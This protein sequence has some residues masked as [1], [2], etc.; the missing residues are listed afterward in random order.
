MKIYPAERVTLIGFELFMGVMAVVCGFILMVGQAGAIMSMQVDVLEGS[1]FRSFTLPGIILALA[2]GGS[3]LAA[4][5]GLWRH[6]QW[7]PAAS[8]AAGLILMGW[9]AG[10]VVLLGW[11]APKFLQPFCFLYGAAI[12][13]VAL[14][15]VREYAT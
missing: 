3:Q 13:G 1:P 10:E 15:H 11:I 6:D 5:Y 12:A 2:V 9:I 8:V 7:G 14:R 4:A